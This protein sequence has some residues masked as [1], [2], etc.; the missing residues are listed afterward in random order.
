MGKA[1]ESGYFRRNNSLKNLA[2]S[3]SCATSARQVSDQRDHKKH[4]EDKEQ[5][6]GD[7]SGGYRDTT[8]SE[9][10]GNNRHYQKD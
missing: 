3:N 4:K 1:K 10:R 9:D 6:L 2:L 5:N 7:S 8:K